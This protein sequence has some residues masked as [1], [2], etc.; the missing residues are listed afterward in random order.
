MRLIG[1][2][3]SSVTAPCYAWVA[4]QLPGVALMSISGGTD[5]VSAL[6]LGAPTVPVWPGELSCPALGVALDAFNDNGGPVPQPG[7]LVGRI[8]ADAHDAGLP[9]ERP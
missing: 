3:G 8:G 9:M 6:A 1:A 4:H 7:G 5:I 2:T